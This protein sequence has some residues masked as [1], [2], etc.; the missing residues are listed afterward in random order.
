MAAEEP[1]FLEP[2]LASLATHGIRVGVADYRRI[3]TALQAR[4]DWTLARLRDL[5]TALLARDREQALALPGRFDRFFAQRPPPA[6]EPLDLELLLS[7]LRALVEAPP[8]PAPARPVP[9]AAPTPKPK[10]PNRFP[11]PLAV[12]LGLIALVGVLWIAVL[13]RPAPPSVSVPIPVPPQPGPATPVLPDT[14][15]PAPEAPPPSQPEPEPEPEPAPAPIPTARFHH[16]EMTLARVPFV[17]DQAWHAPAATAAAALLALLFYG[18]WVWRRVR[19]PRIVKPEEDP[20]KPRLFSIAEVGGAPAPRFDAATLDAVADTL[21]HTLG[22]AP[23]GRLAVAAT[24]RATLAHHGIPHLVFARRR[25]P[26][27]V[28]LLLDEYAQAVQWNPVA[29]ELA[30]GLGPRGVACTL[31]RFRGD[32][33]RFTTP[34]GRAHHL[35]DWED[36]RTSHLLLIVSDARGL[37]PAR[38]RLVLERLRHWPLLAWLD[39]RE[40]RAWD[41]FTQVPAAAGIPLYP[42]T[43]RG[44]LGAVLALVGEQGA[45]AL[46]EQDQGPRV[47]AGL[48]SPPRRAELGLDAPGLAAYLEQSLGDALPW[49]QTCALVQPI[50]P[51]LAERLRERFFPDLPAAAIERLHTLPGTGRSVAGLHFSLEVQGALRRGLAAR[52]DPARRRAVIEFLLAQID[53]ARPDADPDSLRLLAWELARERLALEGEP[54]N[55]A[56]ARRLA[57]LAQ[58]SLGDGLRDALAPFGERRLPLLGQPSDPRARAWLS[59]IAGDP[60]RLRLGRVRRQPLGP[61]RWAVVGLLSAVALGAGGL[62]YFKARDPVGPDR[63]AL[64]WQAQGEPPGNLYTLIEERLPGEPWRERAAA[65]GLPVDIDAAPWDAER[66]YRLALVA[67]GTVHPVAEL[68]DPTERLTVALGWGER[69]RP[70]REPAGAPGLELERRDCPDDIAPDAPPRAGW[71][72]RLGSLAPEGRVLSIALAVQAPGRPDAA[73]AL[74]S[75]LLASGSVDRVYRLTADPRD[76]RALDGALGQVA[77]DLGPGLG[78]AQLLI[79][80][81]AAMLDGAGRAALR[82]SAGDRG[83]QAWLILPGAPGAWDLAYAPVLRL[84]EPDEAGPVLESDLLAAVGAETALRGGGAPVVLIRPAQWVIAVVFHTNP[85]DARIALARGGR[86]IAA[87]HGEPVMLDSGA[88][89]VR[90]EAA[91]RRP[92]SFALDVGPETS[93]KPIEVALEPVV[94]DFAV[95]RDPL[96]SGGEGPAMVRIPDGGFLMG[97]PKD[98]PEPERDDDEEQHQ[99]Q[100]KQP[101]AIGKYEVTVAEFRRFAEAGKGYRTEAERGDGC[102]GWKNGTWQQ[103]KA[104]SW[105][106]VGFAQGDDSPVVCVSWNDARAYTTW[107]SEQTGKTYRLPTEAQWEYAARALT[108]KPFFTGDCISTKQANYNGTGDYNNCSAKTGVYSVKTLPVGSFKANAWGLCDLA[109]NAWEWTCSAYVASYDGKEQVCIS[110]NDVKSGLPRVFRGGSWS[111]RPAWVRSANRS[112]YSPSY[113]FDN[114]GFRLAQDL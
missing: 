44:V 77:A 110:N 101:F 93:S 79:Y 75:R 91:D 22:P 68:S 63:I 3:A 108:T 28:L 105:R 69:P 64:D 73:D 47:R 96:K 74:G 2:F 18:V 16:P 39:P 71:R 65:P 80:G 15:Q 94:V 1:P 76:P 9:S 57:A 50:P 31:G 17:P 106:A 56:H 29:E 84:L 48:P 13:L 20:K 103:V 90:V 34:E 27:G 59:G 46:A 61:G 83:F 62:G 43:P 95:F 5:L 98:E 23:G 53:Q 30:A 51:G 7:E 81:D 78:H 25:R 38:R 92:Q 6:G 66:E 87:R 24:V 36:R 82:R 41:A 14:P 10:D 60:L 33:E 40:P 86:V 35:E 12:L 99:V 109:G 104:F 67:N 45:G 8:S 70:C 72:Q 26:R 11:R 32:P 112:G 42:A 4:Q 89:Q 85:E 107:L 58:T 54:E 55:P 113:R 52:W 49:A 111:S 37:D 97:S 114:L 19:I 88:W 100:I 102:Y 21:G